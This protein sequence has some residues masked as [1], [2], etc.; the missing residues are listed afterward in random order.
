M[1]ERFRR[2]V[3]HLRLRPPHRSRGSAPR[4]RRRTHASADR[5]RP[6]RTRGA[7][8]RAGPHG[9]TRQPFHHGTR[10]RTRPARHYFRSAMGQGDQQ[11]SWPRRRHASSTASA[12][13]EGVRTARRRAAAHADRRSHHRAGRPAHHRRALRRRL[14]HRPPLPDTGHL[15]P[16]G[17]AAR[18]LAT[19]LRLDRRHEKDFRLE[20][21]QRR[22][23]D[24]CG[25]GPTRRLPRGPGRSPARIAGR[26]P[27]LRPHPR[28]RRRRPSH[29]TTKYSC[30][31]PPCS[32][33]APTPLA[34]SWPQRCRCCA[35]TP[36]SGPYLPSIPNW[37]PT[38]STR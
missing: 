37:Q 17:R 14:R 9:A 27:D 29:A 28:R 32:P 13:V 1:P 18:G 22:P 38:R 33:P 26:R 10:P 35:P 19:V 4:H 6:A 36:T 7:Q 12:G 20:R 8:L 15:R 5:N 31:A 30:C 11:H 24:P 25:M 3:A 16:A 21:R 2:W 23:G 34:T